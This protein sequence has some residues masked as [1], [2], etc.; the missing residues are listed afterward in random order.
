M[1]N[2]PAI[3]RWYKLHIVF[4]DPDLR[5]SDTEYGR[6]IHLIKALRNAYAK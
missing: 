4:D 1:T 3:L 2:P 5:M 6:Q